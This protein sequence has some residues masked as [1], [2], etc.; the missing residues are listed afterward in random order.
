MSS[1]LKSQSKQ[2]SK[3]AFIATFQGYDDESNL[4]VSF[5]NTFSNLFPTAILNYIPICMGIPI[6]GPIIPGPT[7]PLSESI[8]M[9]GQKSFE[10]TFQGYGDEQ[11]ISHLFANT[12]KTIATPISIYI[13]TCLT[14]PPIP[15]SLVSPGGPIIISPHASLQTQILNI[16]KQA[17]EATFQGYDDDANLSTLFS[18]QFQFIASEI[19]L[20]ISRCISLPG[21]GPIVP[22]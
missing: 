17:F 2:I 16:S 3:D 5:S 15:P 12:L 14:L 9:A 13:S 20:Y 22:V 19:S 21:G 18:N 7:T 10:A 4:A 1:I 11:Q 6:G 8:Y